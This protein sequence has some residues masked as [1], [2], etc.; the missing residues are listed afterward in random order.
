[1]WGRER[2]YI[3]SRRSQSII[4]PLSSY[5]A[6]F[7]D[8]ISTTC[9]DWPESANVLKTTF[10][11]RINISCGKQKGV[12]AKRAQTVIRAGHCVTGRNPCQSADEYRSLGAECIKHSSLSLKICVFDVISWEQLNREETNI[13][14]GEA[15]A[16]PILGGLCFE[17]WLCVCNTAFS[18][19]GLEHEAS[20]LGPFS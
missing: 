18:S 17:Q 16:F 13:T 6:H 20:K 12:F 10:I 5:F 3:M 9:I 1:M 2:L 11:N 14:I 15:E 7:T 8:W 4:F 19:P